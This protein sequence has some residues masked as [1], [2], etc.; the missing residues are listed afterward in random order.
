MWIP[1]I[2]NHFSGKKKL[3]KHDD[4]KHRDILVGPQTHARTDNQ[5]NSADLRHAA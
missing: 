4:G 3:I 5:K 1:K 2:L